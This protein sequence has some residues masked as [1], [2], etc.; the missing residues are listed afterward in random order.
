MSPVL[1]VIYLIFTTHN[2]CLL[3]WSVSSKS[4]EILEAN[5]F[6]SFLNWHYP[7]QKSSKEN[8][9]LISEAEYANEVEKEMVVHP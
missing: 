3:Y 2:I 9:T 8:V 5:K 7:L 4:K 6:K 1:F